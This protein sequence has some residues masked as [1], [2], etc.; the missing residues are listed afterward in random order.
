MLSGHLHLIMA[1]TYPLLYEIENFCQVDFD[2]GS[3]GLQNLF[4][5]HAISSVSSPEDCTAAHLL[6]F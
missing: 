6:T 3:Q 5:E 4:I 1:V 2:N